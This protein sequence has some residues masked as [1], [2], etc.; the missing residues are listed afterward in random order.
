MADLVIWRRR[1]NSIAIR[2]GGQYLAAFPIGLKKIL[3]RL[4]IG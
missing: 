1:S 4:T 2:D 3:A